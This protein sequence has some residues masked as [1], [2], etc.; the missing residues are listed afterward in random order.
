MKQNPK[1]T[2]TTRLSID[3]PKA[4]YF[5]LQVIVKANGETKAAHIRSLILKD[6]QAPK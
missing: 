2:T 3:L 4:L 5:R 6:L 1:P